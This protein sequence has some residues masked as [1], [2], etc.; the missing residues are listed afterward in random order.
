MGTT[1]VFTAELGRYLFLYLEGHW[2]DQQGWIYI[3]AIQLYM[4]GVIC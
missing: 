1:A 3:Q 2:L 4:L